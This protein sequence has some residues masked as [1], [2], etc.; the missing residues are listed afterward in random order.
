V[1]APV[2][3]ALFRQLLVWNAVRSWA[4]RE[5]MEGTEAAEEARVAAEDAASAAKAAAAA[6]VIAV[7]RCCDEETAI[8][9]MP[10]SPAASPRGCDTAT[11]ARAISAADVA[12]LLAAAA[13]D[14]NANADAD[15]DA[16]SASP[17]APPLPPLSPRAAAAAL[18]ELCVAHPLL[19]AGAGLLVFAAQAA[20]L[21]ASLAAAAALTGSASS[22]S[23]AAAAS[24]LLHYRLC[25]LAL[26]VLTVCAGALVLRGELARCAAAPRLRATVCVATLVGACTLG[27]A[28]LLTAGVPGVDG[29]DLAV[30]TCTAAASLLVRARARALTCCDALSLLS[31]VVVVCA[32]RDVSDAHLARP[33]LAAAQ[34]FLWNGVRFW[35]LAG[36]RDDDD[37]DDEAD[38]D[39]DDD[40]GEALLL[41]FD[42]TADAIGDDVAAQKAAALEAYAAAASAKAAAA[43]EKAEKAEKLQR[44]RMAE[45]DAAAAAVLWGG[46]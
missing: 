33:P 25:S 35:A 24:R 19:H 45:R 41:D 37:D 30:T 7:S 9:G 32:R 43:S 1:C 17:R 14:V 15:D 46:I 39:D 38:S 3:H 6:K 23:D 11:A 34:L 26:D 13:E 4:L 5:W 8:T 2:L 12:A 10:A 40:D 42:A 16:C 20:L 27:Y 36:W 31:C 28:L 22:S 18:T 29:P 44:E 21:T